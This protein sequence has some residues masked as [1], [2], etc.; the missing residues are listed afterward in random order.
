MQELYRGETF[1]LVLFDLSGLFFPLYAKNQFELVSAQEVREK[2]IDE[3]GYKLVE[4][5]EIL[6]YADATRRNEKEWKSGNGR[7]FLMN[8]IIRKDERDEV[9]TYCGPY[10]DTGNYGYE[11]GLWREKINPTEEDFPVLRP[12]P[13]QLKYRVLSSLVVKQVL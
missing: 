7:R 8:P 6:A 5:K 9:I 10:P 12:H 2:I 4:E 1:C 13:V 11:V 3:L